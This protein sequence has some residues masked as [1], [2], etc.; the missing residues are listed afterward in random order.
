MNHEGKAGYREL[1][2]WKSHLAECGMLS[3]WEETV[4]YDPYQDRVNG[5]MVTRE[6]TAS[7]A[8]L[9][10]HGLDDKDCVR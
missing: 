10:K 4:R 3:R 6:G 5:V 9:Q 8:I 2:F 7:L 1:V